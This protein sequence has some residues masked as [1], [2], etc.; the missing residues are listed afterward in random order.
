MQN[1]QTESE[2]KR[3]WPIVFAS[4]LGIGLGLSPL[5]FYTMGIFAPHL[6]KEF[7]WAREEIQFGITM[8]TLMVLWAGPVVG[9][10]V[11]R[12]NVRKL[13]LWALVLFSLS[14]MALGL[15][16]GS[17]TQYYVTWALVGMFGAA[18]L[19]ITWT[20]VV[21][22]WFDRQRGM[23]LGLSLMGT[24]LFGFAAQYFIPPIIE[25][26][27]WRVAY[28]AVGALPLL[29]AGPVAW[30][31]FFD[32]EERADGAPL[33][34][35][36]GMTTGETLRDWRFW[37]MCFGF[38]GISLMLGGIPPN[39]PD[40]LTQDGMGMAEA[41]KL[42]SLVGL[43]AIA[44]RLIGGWL[45]DRVWAPLVCLILLGAPAIACWM[46]SQGNLEP[47]TAAAAILLIGF[48]L[49]VEFDLMAFMLGRYF[50]LKSYSLN[51]AILY[52]FFSLGAGFGPP[53]LARAAR[54]DG[55]YGSILMIAAIALIFISSSF[56]LL[57]RYR[58]FEEKA[59]AN[60]APLE[61]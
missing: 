59:G 39:L 61:T 3:G 5:P 41:L 42:T 29:I 8:T 16:S 35:T 6:A 53:M 51:Y 38:L 14:F 28:G 9:L 21:N 22:G 36:T 54:L 27:G 37:L 12:M 30:F 56:L 24:G 49:G 4:F 45:I 13:V 52:I 10:L 48:A 43:S 15:S 40:M 34:A 1:S 47:G 18:T 25:A 20:R 11:N 31:L 26:F 2:F 50:G 58:N 32:Q 33:Y 60:G 19:P 44:G 23:A 55:G 57:G 17:L 46:L 7:G